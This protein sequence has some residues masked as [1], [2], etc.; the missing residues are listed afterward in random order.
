MNRERYNIDTDFLRKP[1]QLVVGVLDSQIKPICMNKEGLRNAALHPRL[2]L[3]GARAGI[4]LAFQGCIGATPDDFKCPVVSLRPN[5]GIDMKS[6]PPEGEAILQ[7]SD[8]T[9]V[10]KL[11]FH[12]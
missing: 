9:L 4:G 8:K 1:I 3:L 6:F 5:L 2:Q 10:Q 12:L 7:I 11:I